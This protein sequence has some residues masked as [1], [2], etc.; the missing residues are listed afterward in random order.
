MLRPSTRRR[1]N[2][3]R[4]LLTLDHILTQTAPALPD[5]R[6][7]VEPNGDLTGSVPPLASEEEVRETFT[8]WVDHLGA[9]LADDVRGDDRLELHAFMPHY[10][11]QLVYVTVRATVPNVLREGVGV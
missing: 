7:T 9:R 11:D 4:A 3:A 1:A 6:W 2:Q 8:G 10:G 5:L